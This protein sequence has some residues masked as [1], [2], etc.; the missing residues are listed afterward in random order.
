MRQV[1]KHT[2]LVVL[3]VQAGLEW[4]ATK[5]FKNF[6]PGTFADIV[7]NSQKL[8]DDFEKKGVPV[9]LVTVSP[10]FFPHSIREKFAKKRVISDSAYQ[11]LKHSGDVF[12]QAELMKLFKQLEIS[13]VIFTGFSADNAVIKAYR[14]SRKNG[15]EPIVVKDAVGAKSQKIYEDVF[16]EIKNTVTTN[17]LLYG[18]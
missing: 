10:S 17:Q 12:D 4:M 16:A 11:I 5:L 13:Q 8:V 7:A 15:L 3:D 18:E 1:D 6:Y 14:S 2:A 9:V